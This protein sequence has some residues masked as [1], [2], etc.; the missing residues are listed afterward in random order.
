MAYTRRQIVT[1][2]GS[3]G[4]VAL[5][6]TLGLLS[7][8]LAC[9]ATWPGA[10]FEARTLGEV[11]NALG[12]AEVTEH[13]HLALSVPDIAENGAVVPVGMMSQLPGTETMALLVEKNTTV[14][15]A[16]FVFPEGT[17]PEV[18]T[19]IKMAQTSWVFAVAKA[20]GGF[21][22]ARKEVQ[23]VRGGCEV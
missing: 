6:R 8:E 4:M 16:R 13:H 10:A 3:A 17:L 18:Q 22:L 12:V 21:Y 15:V 1:H 5:C 23:V 9:A 20:A 2:V 14:L 19:R 11:F 7:P